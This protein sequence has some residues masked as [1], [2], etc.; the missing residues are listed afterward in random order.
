MHCYPCQS[1]AIIITAV[2][3]TVDLALLNLCCFIVSMKINDVVP[4]M[5]KQ[6][7]F[8]VHINFKFVQDSRFMSNCRHYIILTDEILIDSGNQL[9]SN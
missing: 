2:K 4:K 9:N 6:F 3:V 8:V 1:T 7:T 5:F